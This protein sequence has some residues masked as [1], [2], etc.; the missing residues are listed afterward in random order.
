MS[1]VVSP[2]SPPAVPAAPP[3]RRSV[4]L[5]LITLATGGMLGRI[6]A[7]D[8]IDKYGIERELQKRDPQR[9]ISRPFLSANDRS[10][11]ATVRALVEHG[12]YAI[13]EVIRE[14]GW[15]TID[16]VKHVGPDGQEHLY[17]SKPPLFATILAGPYWL[18][19]RITG[20]TLGDHPYASAGQCWSCSPW[21]PWSFI[22]SP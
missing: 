17:S 19:H 3:L 9:H 21:S 15:D 16:M 13:D 6:L 7:V 20:A 12:T 18:I 11:W 1:A 5:L 14:P 4:Y 8:S 2:E 10:R 22:F